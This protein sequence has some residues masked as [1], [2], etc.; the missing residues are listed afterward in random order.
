MNEIEIQQRRINHWL[1]YHTDYQVT[2]H[3]NTVYGCIDVQITKDNEHI[4]AY[5]GNNLAKRFDEVI[6]FLKIDEWEGEKKWWKFM[7][8]EV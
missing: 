4:K 1:R 3:L 5:I 6:K 7:E 8:K 2:I